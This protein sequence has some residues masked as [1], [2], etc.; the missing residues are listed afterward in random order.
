MPAT[1]K[2]TRLDSR[3]RSKPPGNPPPA[4]RAHKVPASPAAWTFDVPPVEVE[5]KVGFVR[6]DQ[7]IVQRYVV[8]G[9]GFSW[10]GD[11]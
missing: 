3:A 7:D 8:P 1:P 10:D 5:V 4:V 11:V 2:C 9:V 6:F